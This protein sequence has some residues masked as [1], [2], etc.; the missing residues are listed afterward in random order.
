MEHKNEIDNVNFYG[1]RELV[2]SC[3]D[4]LSDNNNAFHLF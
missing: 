2:T 1:T 3:D 4:F